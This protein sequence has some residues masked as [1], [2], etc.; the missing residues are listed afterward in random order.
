MGRGNRGLSGMF[1]A[2]D[3]KHLLGTFDIIHTVVLIR[4]IY[5]LEISVKHNNFCRIFMFAPCINSFKALF[6]I[7]NLCTLLKIIGIL[8]H[9]KFRLSLRNVSV[10]AG[11]IIRELPPPCTAHSHNRLVCRHDID[12]V[13]NDEHI[14][15]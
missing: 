1:T 8:K 9:L 13:S 10:H 7:P 15:S 4:H 2:A 12:Y 14:E 11:T 3:N 5:W 6:I